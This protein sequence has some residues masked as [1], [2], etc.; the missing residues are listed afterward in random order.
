MPLRAIEIINTF[1]YQIMAFR[2]SHAIVKMQ[3]ETADFASGV[4]IWRTKR[5]IRVIFGPSQFPA[6]YI[7]ILVFTLYY[8]CSPKFLINKEIN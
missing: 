6:L 3:S 4:A 8:L 2:K 7:F 5:N 1:T